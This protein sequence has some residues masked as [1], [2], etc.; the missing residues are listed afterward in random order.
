MTRHLVLI[1]LAT[2]T[3]VG[4][5]KDEAAQAKPIEHAPAF[6]PDMVSPLLQ[7]L[8]LEKASVED[9]LAVF[10]TTNLSKD[11]A[12]GGDQSVTWNDQPAIAGRIDAS[13]YANATDPVPRASFTWVEMDGE[14]RL[15]QLEVSFD[16]A[17]VDS[18][19]AWVKQRFSEL[20]QARDCEGAFSS[21][22]ESDTRLVYCVGNAAQTRPI[23]IECEKVSRD[24]RQL[25]R[26]RYELQRSR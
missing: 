15:Q 11:R 6:T 16:T 23:A 2:A 1:L 24:G 17:H 20:E 10:P 18:P 7:G 3:L 13:L 21:F 12:F 19:C 8:Q 22:E 9:V 4:C 26:L 25:E 14:I 5:K